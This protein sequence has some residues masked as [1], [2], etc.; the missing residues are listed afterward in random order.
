M[1]E[2]EAPSNP[3]LLARSGGGR[4]DLTLTA[5][6]PPWVEDPGRAR[7]AEQREGGEP[8]HPAFC[9]TLLLGLL[10]L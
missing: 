1:V 4:A 10:Q 2:G 9:V 5:L 3:Q 6:E 7:T 8:G